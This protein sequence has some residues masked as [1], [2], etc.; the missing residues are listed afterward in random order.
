LLLL[1]RSGRFSPGPKK[2]GSKRSNCIYSLL[3]YERFRQGRKHKRN[4]IYLSEY[5]LQEL[6]ENI[7]LLE[8]AE[9]LS[10]ASEKDSNANHI[11]N[12]DRPL[13]KKEV[14]NSALKV[15]GILINVLGSAL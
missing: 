3:W 5:I 15:G 14:S 1:P 7:R 8:K 9:H 2:E 12:N 6:K 13:T 11:N 4:L 10:S